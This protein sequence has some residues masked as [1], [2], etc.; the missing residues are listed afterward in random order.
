MA[1]FQV[2]KVSSKTVPTA[3]KQDFSL[4]FDPST[5]HIMGTIGR[6]AHS[7]VYCYHDPFQDRLYAVKAQ[8]RGDVK[9]RQFHREVHILARLKGSPW[10]LS[11]ISAFYDVTSFHIVTDM[12]VTNVALAVGQC[13]LP[14]GHMPLDMVCHL[15]AEILVALDEL[16]AHRIIHGDLKPENILVDVYGHIVL[17]DFGL[18]RDFNQLRPRDQILGENTSRPDVTFARRGAGVYR[19]PQAWMGLPFSYETDHWAMG[20]IVHWCLFNQYPFGVEIGDASGSIMDAVLLEPYD[21]DEESYT[22]HPYTGDL[23]RRIFDK[24][25][26]SRIDASAMKRHPFFA[27]VEWDGIRRREHQGPFWHILPENVRIP[28]VS[29]KP[30]QADGKLPEI[31]IPIEPGDDSSERIPSQPMADLSVITEVTAEM[32]APPEA[33]LLWTP[34]TSQI[35]VFYLLLL[36]PPLIPLLFF[37]VAFF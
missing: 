13:R 26:F 12:H 34:D 22:V 25:P 24:S 21:L 35:W 6:G 17:S 7:K 36:L 4:P 19:C 8:R 20:V 11:L 3:E 37:T 33:R 27:D 23:L 16:H 30:T 29:D 9:Y 31:E 1:A 15:V 5:V 2:V 28:A 14:E 32:F 10:L 18:S